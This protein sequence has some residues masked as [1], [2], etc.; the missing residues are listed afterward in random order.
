MY[1]KKTYLLSLLT[2]LLLFLLMYEQDM[3]LIVKG[4]KDHDNCGKYTIDLK[5]TTPI[6]I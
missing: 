1:D 3:N 6:I 4:S 5:R 2:T